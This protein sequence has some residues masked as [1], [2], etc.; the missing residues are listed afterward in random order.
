MHQSLCK[1]LDHVRAANVL[2]DAGLLVPG[3]GRH[4]MPKVA[5]AGYGRPR[6]Y[7]VKGAILGGSDE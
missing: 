6:V 2:K 7:F 1:G 4:L 5:I 3:E